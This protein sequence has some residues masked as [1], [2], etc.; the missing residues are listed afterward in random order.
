MSDD[1]WPSP[2]HSS[3]AVTTAEYEQKFAPVLPEGIVGLHSDT[4]AVYGDS[5]GRQVKVRANRWGMVRGFEWYSGTVDFTVAIAANSSGSTRIDRI[6]LRIDRGDNFKVRVAVRQGTAG[7]GLPA[8]VQNVGSSYLNSGTYEIA[9]AHVTVVNGA[10]SISASDVVYV[11]PLIQS[12]NS[13]QPLGIIGGNKWV[14]SGLLA[15]GT[16]YFSTNQATGVSTPVINFRAG[17]RYRLEWSFEASY[18]Q[19]NNHIVGL[20]TEFR[21]SPSGTVIGTHR[22][23]AFETV[24]AWTLKAEMFYEPSA[25]ESTAL[26]LHGQY[27][28]HSGSGTFNWVGINKSAGNTFFVVHDIGAAAGITSA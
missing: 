27:L 9:L 4:A 3:G 17:R 10:S 21:K 20:S 26:S 15:G 7:A 13:G 14:G 1:S 28:Y 25:D 23:P 19:T 6:V 24:Q 8:L 11:A 18:S 22:I 16:A 5:S 12:N 2:A